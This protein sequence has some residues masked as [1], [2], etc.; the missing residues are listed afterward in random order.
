M[1][2]VG[3]LGDHICKV[4]EETIIELGNCL[5][6]Q[7]LSALSEQLRRSHESIRR[8]CYDHHI[9]GDLD[10][11]YSKYSRLFDMPLPRFQDGSD[12]ELRFALSDLRFTERSILDSLTEGSHGLYVAAYPGDKPKTVKQLHRLIRKYKVVQ[13]HTVSNQTRGSQRYVGSES[14]S[15]LAGSLTGDGAGIEHAV[16]FMERQISR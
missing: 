11:V 3:E 14:R 8:N 15:Q 6:V 5:L 1:K 10:H 2:V 16:S 12:D 7:D 13:N 9:C 4:V